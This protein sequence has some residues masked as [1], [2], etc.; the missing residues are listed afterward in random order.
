VPPKKKGD[1]G[2]L[3][4]IIRSMKRT[5]KAA[6]ILPHGVLFR[7][8]AEAVIRQQ[9]IRSGYLKA[10]IG[11]PANLFYGTGIPA[12]ILVLDKE[13]ATAR[14]GI[15][16]ID[17]SK[18]FRKDGPKNRLREQDIHR[19]VDTFTRQDETDPRYARMVP[20]EEIA[21]PKN[22]YNLNLPR[23]IDSTEPEDLQDI[24][25]HLRG[26]IPERDID[27]PVRLQ[28][29]WKTLPGVRAVVFEKA[30]RP[31][32]CRLRIPVA[33]VKA[34]IFGHREFAA[35][36]N[37][38]TAVFDAWKKANNP[39]L[40]GF[41][42]GGHPK[43]LSE[44]IAEHLLAA[45]K[46]APL[47]DAYDLYQHLMDYWA[48]TM[49]D[50]CYLIAAE[51]WK[52]GAQPREILQVKN[53]EKKLVW[54]EP[55]D[56]KR[57]KRRFKSDLIPAALLIDRYFAAERDAIAAI[58]AELAAIEQQMDE[59]RE[60]QS[61]EEGLLSAVIEGEGDKQ[62]VT[63]KAVKAQ[64]KEIGEDPDFADEREALEEYAALLDRQVDAKARL[65]TAQEDLEANLDAKYPKLKEDEI[66]T[67]VVD[68]KW[69]ATIAAAVQSELDRVSQTLTG[70]I[71]LLAE[72]YATPLPQLTDEVSTLAS[73][74]DEH[75]KR[76]G[77]VWK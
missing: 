65:R 40:K 2:Y 49:Q 1:Y 38:A 57:G 61:G 43:Q 37:S 20:V 3:L 72:R 73:R 15:F 23:Y 13:N 77:A 45:F 24:D 14:K 66:K 7:G 32:Y 64:L 71:R 74:V 68:D 59:T 60:E 22:D 52:A 19:I 16:L 44:T 4:H 70:R 29:Y 69:L 39:R 18:G 12:C 55:H 75:L 42:K 53:K 56:F 33:E 21:D 35:F 36:Q 27:D 58:E 11:L 5:G 31:G 41:T 76:M 67:L 34:A 8:N 47:L 10:I 26:G 50:D 48:D 9:L 6:C 17:A 25:A 63:A 51:G 54:P 28:H 62:K 30:G 46:A